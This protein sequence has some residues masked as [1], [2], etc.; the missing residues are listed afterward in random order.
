METGHHIENLDGFGDN[1]TFEIV[2]LCILDTTC[3]E[4]DAGVSSSGQR[5]A[6][7][8]STTERK[9]LILLRDYQLL[10]SLCFIPW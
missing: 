2:H 8:G 3:S 5:T 9:F 6:Y 1:I 7:S 4:Y 10:Q